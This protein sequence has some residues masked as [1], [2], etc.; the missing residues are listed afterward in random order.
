VSALLLVQ[1]GSTPPAP[2]RASDFDVRRAAELAQLCSPSNVAGVGL[3]GQYFA[4][5]DCRGTPMIVRTDATVDFDA[6]LAWPDPLRRPRSAR[7]DGWVKPVF[8]GRYR[9]HIDEPNSEIVVAHQRMTGMA[10]DPGQ[11]IE[12][13]AGRFYPIRVSLNR[14][15]SQGRVRLEWTVPHGARFL[16]PRALLYLPTETA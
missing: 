8:A 11:V 9:F 1:R 4:Q 5:A 16:V 2:A 6:A 10:G 13:Q 14:W 15:P 12:L 7:W 3:R